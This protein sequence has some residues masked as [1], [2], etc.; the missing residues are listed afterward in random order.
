MH[1]VRRATKKAPFVFS[2]AGIE[3]D[4]AHTTWL[5]AL[6]SVDKPVTVLAGDF[7]LQVLEIDQHMQSLPEDSKPFG[8]Q[9]T[10]DI[11]VRPFFHH[12]FEVLMH[13]KSYAVGKYALVGNPGTGKSWL[14]GYI[15]WEL[16]LA[17]R[18]EQA[19][20]RERRSFA[21]ELV[22]RQVGDTQLFLYALGPNRE[23]VQ[24]WVVEKDRSIIKEMLRLFQGNRSVLFLYDPGESHMPLEVYNLHIVATL[25]PRA[26]RTKHFLR[27]DSGVDRFM[28]IWSRDELLA[29]GRYLYRKLRDTDPRKALF[30]DEKIEERLDQFG[31][32]ARYVLPSSQEKLDEYLAEQAAAFQTITFSILTKAGTGIDADDAKDN[33]S[34]FFL[35]YEVNAE[36]FVDKRLV[37]P[38]RYVELWIRAQAV[39]IAFVDAVHSLGQAIMGHLPERARPLLETV[40]FGMLERKVRNWQVTFPSPSPASTPSDTSQSDD[41]EQSLTVADSTAELSTKT[42]GRSSKAQSDVTQPSQQQQQQKKKRPLAQAESEA[43]GVAQ[44]PRVAQ[45][46]SRLVESLNEQPAYESVTYV[47]HKHIP[48]FDEMTEGALYIPGKTTFPLVEAVSRVKGR[49]EGVQCKSGRSAKFEPSTCVALRRDLGLAMTVPIHV[50]VVTTTSYSGEWCELIRDPWKR[51]IKKAH[52]S[53][54]QQEQAIANVSFA[55]VTHSFQISDL[56]D[57]HVG[58]LVLGSD[59]AAIERADQEHDPVYDRKRTRY[60]DV[61]ENAAVEAAALETLLRHFQR[62]GNAGGGDCLFHAIGQ[63][64]GDSGESVRAKIVQYYRDNSEW[65][66][67][68]LQN[69]GV[70]GVISVKLEDLSTAGVST[71]EEYVTYMSNAGTW[72]NNLEVVAA[73][74]FYQRCIIVH[75]P[76]KFQYPIEPD[77]SDEQLGDPIDLL[78]WGEHYELLVPHAVATASQP[79]SL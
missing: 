17:Q 6:A 75:K 49:L 13:S 4:E 52:A 30:I 69:T 32:I 39:K 22:L 2:D 79:V 65:L 51:P 71:A 56:G 31:G 76:G 27:N 8:D 24:A 57:V 54:A 72:A 28:P 41:Q 55:V 34:H 77:L 44:A 7:M 64:V 15:L 40:T 59:P 9:I 11:I 38:S 50:W 36:N 73:A 45:V 48:T 78:L 26:D 37:Y 19:A 70:D 67:D 1:Y 74:R 12:L 46:P 68:Q 14:H 29:A 16:L 5:R 60:E 58:G 66:Q 61:E 25:S 3:V 21:F 42:R 18:R 23:A 10:H 35:Q 63:A 20:S 43:P 62:V 47:H 33:V 53:V